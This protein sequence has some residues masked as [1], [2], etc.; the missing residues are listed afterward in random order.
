LEYYKDLQI[1]NKQVKASSNNINTLNNI[2]TN[3][4]TNVSHN[5]TRIKKW[6]IYTIEL[7]VLEDNL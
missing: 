7:I 2:N 5:D 4:K 1:N 6:K 3:I